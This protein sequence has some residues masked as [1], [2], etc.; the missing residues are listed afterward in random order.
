MISFEEFEA[1]KE[2][3]PPEFQFIKCHDFIFQD[4]RKVGP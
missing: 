3:R 4:R 1:D 2:N